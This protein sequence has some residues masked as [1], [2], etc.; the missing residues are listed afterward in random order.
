MIQEIKDEIIEGSPKYNITD[1]ADGT[2]NIELANEI[3]QEGT[4]LN[5]SFFEN[6]KSDISEYELL[7]YEQEDVSN[8]IG[9]VSTTVTSQN[10]AGICLGNKN[11]QSYPFNII[12]NKVF[13]LS[14]NDPYNND[15]I[16]ICGCVNGTAK[17]TLTDISTALNRTSYKSNY[18][19]EIISNTRAGAEIIF[20]WDLLTSK[21]INQLKHH[22]ASTHTTQYEF[23]GSNDN[24]NWTSISSGNISE[25]VN[26]ISG[27]GNSFRYWKLKINVP[28]LSSSQRVNIFIYYLFL[29]GVADTQP[30]FNNKFTSTNDFS[31]IKCKNVLVPSNVDFTN[32]TSNTLN[33]YNIDKMLQ[34]DMR[35]NIMLE[36]N[37]MINGL[38]ILHGVTGVLSYNQSITLDFVPR[39][40]FVQ[41]SNN[42]NKLVKPMQPT[43]TITN[44]GN[45]GSSSTTMSYCAFY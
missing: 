23:I 14:Y 7:T 8:I 35:Y 19:V 10:Y 16:S 11:E 18:Y 4:P 32:V 13:E 1:N 5:K 26:T 39:L 30:K 22:I 6:F 34:P 25:S 42:E 43:K 37:K 40:L 24:T 12:S 44:T 29:N 20:L 2:K 45:G 27:A 38:G 15:F 28:V 41:Y 17:T 31:K 33:G 36:D 21:T 9:Q 3:I